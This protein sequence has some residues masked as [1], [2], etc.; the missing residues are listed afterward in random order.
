MSE[1]IVIG[2]DSAVKARAAYDEVLALQAE[3]VVDLQGWLAI[4]TV[5]AE[6]KTHVETQQKITG[7]AVGAASGALWGL[8]IGLLFLVPVVGVALGGVVGEL[9]AKFA[10]SGVND[11][12]RGRVKDLLKPG[13]AA[14][15]MLAEKIAEDKF[16]E[17]MA[18]YGGQLLR[19]SL[20]EQGKKE[21]AHDLADT[22]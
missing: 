11:I 4:V 5:N 22:Q 2:Y 7:P 13:R 18:P 10:K 8:L 15:V 14:V 21:L 1:L 19:T 6:G 17:R 3:S 12:F 9:V 16:A 20:S